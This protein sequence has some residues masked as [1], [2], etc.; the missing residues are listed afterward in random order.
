MPQLVATPMLEYA[1][2][3]LGADMLFDTAI[4][5]IGEIIIRSGNRNIPEW[6]DDIFTGFILISILLNC[7]L[8]GSGKKE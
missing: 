2:H 3:A 4:D 8:F 1:F 5:L 7:H 6:P